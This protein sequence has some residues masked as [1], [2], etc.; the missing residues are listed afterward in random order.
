VRQ[1]RPE[2]P[3]VV[4][5]LVMRMLAKKPADRFT[6]LREL[7]D[8]VEEIEVR[9]AG[10][11]SILRKTHGP[12]RAMPH[13][14]QPPAE[15]EL[16]PPRARQTSTRPA[17]PPSSGKHA[18]QPIDIPDYLKPVNEAPKKRISDTHTPPLKVAAGSRASDSDR[19]RAKLARVLTRTQHDE[20]ASSVAEAQRA[21]DSGRFIVA[22]D[23]WRRASLL[24]SDLNERARLMKRSRA[25]R[26][27]SRLWRLLR[28]MVGLILVAAVSLVALWYGTPYLHNFLA[29]RELNAVMA[30]QV[31]NP[32]VQRSTLERFIER[33]G[34]PYQWY[35][36]LFRTSYQ[37]AS[38]AE[39]STAI[40]AIDK[41]K[42]SA[43][44]KG[45]ESSSPPTKTGVGGP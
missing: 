13:V 24:V 39:A 36:I 20:V 17:A 42:Q 9:A 30:Q 8:L 6:T 34:R 28:L 10:T 1:F 7:V 33:Q 22:A 29:T 43:P 41:A 19:L 12:F 37:I 16:A 23:A 4:D 21:E 35:E 5:K 38:V 14:Q 25:A 32:E 11:T 27:R 45:R 40:K 15:V 26:R 18:A 44:D 3:E 31:Q 2:T